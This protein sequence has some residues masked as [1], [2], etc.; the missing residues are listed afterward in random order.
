MV[1]KSY[2]TIVMSSD[3]RYDDQDNKITSAIIA[4]ASEDFVSSI[5]SDTSLYGNLDYAVQMINVSVGHED[6][7]Y[8]MPK[9]TV[10]SGI[11]AT[12]SEATL[13]TYTWIFEIILPVLI[14]A[15]GIA[16]WIMRIKK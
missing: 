7:L 8:V 6:S 12:L 1:K 5:W 2:S 4:F 15:G 11:T 13:K 16:I 14:I 9:G 3:T 10:M